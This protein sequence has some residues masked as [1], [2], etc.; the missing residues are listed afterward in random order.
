MSLITDDLSKA[1]I[2][3]AKRMDLNPVTLAFRNRHRKLEEK[4]LADYSASSLLI[5]RVGAILAIVMYSMFGFLDASLAPDNKETL[6]LIRFGF[7]IPCAAFSLL[8]SFLTFFKK[9]LQLVVAFSILTGG[10][11]ILGMMIVAPPPA[12]ISYYAGIL[13]VHMFGYTLVRMRFIY[14]TAANWFVVVCYEVAMVLFSDI[15][16]PILLN[17]NFVLISANIIGMFSCYAMEYYTRRDFFL[18]TLFEKVSQDLQDKNKKLAEEVVLREEISEKLIL[19]KQKAEVANKAKSEFL[20]TMS[21]EI[22]TPMNGIIGMSELLIETGLTGKQRKYSQTIKRSGHALLVIINEIL[23]FSKIEAGKLTLDNH[24]FNLRDLIEETA[25]LMSV[26]AK[27][28]ELD[29]IPALPVDFP[30]TLEGDSVR[31]QQ[32]LINL[33]GNAIKF[34]ESGEVTIRVQ[35]AEQ[36]PETVMV[37]FTVT[38]SGIGISKTQ[39]Q[40][41]FDAFS[42]ADCSTTRQYGGTGLGLAICNQLVQL[43]GGKIEVK[44]APGKGSCFSFSIPLLPVERKKNCEW[45]KDDCSPENLTDIEP[46]PEAGQS[47]VAIGAY[48]L[49]VEDNAVNQDVTKEILALMKCRVDIASNGREAVQ[50]AA[51]NHYDLILMD[52]QMPVMDGFVATAEIRR[53]EQASGE[54]VPIIAMTANVLKDVQDQCRLAGMDDYLSKPFS[55]KDLEKSIKHALDAAEYTKDMEKTVPHDHPKREAHLQE[56]KLPSLRPVNHKVVTDTIDQYLGITPILMETMEQAIRDGDTAVLHEAA[57]SLKSSSANLG[58]MKLS[59]ACSELEELAEQEQTDSAEELLKFV[60]VE[61]QQTCTV[62]NRELE[63]LG[64]D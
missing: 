20:A 8:F 16:D 3:R 11:A 15:S 24:E 44:S 1:G 60:E 29:L 48:I 5:I 18:A 56:E 7:A 35:V 50:A 37:R 47:L 63:K 45:A 22:R 4:F 61:Y 49:L 57:H 13:L 58:A 25:K 41:I 52:C 2:S 34:T 33:L 12:N 53:Q 38:D 43:M 9:H 39:Q 21:H 42:Q 27:D 10:L 64:A 62:L 32:V 59:V 17:N 31:L 55:M 51:A 6:W 30:E 46:V 19:E 14:A 54:H 23:D 36:S 40:H 28:K 26:S